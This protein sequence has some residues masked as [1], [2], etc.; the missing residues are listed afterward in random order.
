MDDASMTQTGVIAGTPQYMSPEQARGESVD[1]RS[2]LFSLGSVLYT[3]CTGRPP[4]RSEAAYGILRRITDSD[5]RPIREI[6]SD[7]PEWLCII[8]E[9][10]L[11]KHPADRFESASEVVDLFDGCLAHLQQP[12]QVELPQS[13][14]GKPTVHDTS[15]PLAS[16]IE[17][18]EAQRQLAPLTQH[19]QPALQPQ[20]SF[21]NRGLI[22]IGSILAATILGLL[23]MQMTNPTDIS[24]HWTG[25][26]WQHVS[27]ASVNEASDWYSGTFVD[28]SG[29][30]GAVRLEWSRLQR[31]YTGRWKVGEAESGEI[32][33]RSGDNGTLRGAVSVDPESQLEP[34]VPRLMEF[35][36]R[37]A[38]QKAQQD[39]ESNAG[40]S[41]STL[42]G[43]ARQSARSVSIRSPTQ[44]I[45]V[46]MAD[47][48]ELNAGVKR[49]D[50]IAELDT[51]A[52]D[53]VVSLK[54]RLSSLELD[55]EA[56]K[57]KIVA[58][59]RGLY[60]SRQISD[61]IMSQIKNLETV[62][63]RAA[64]AFKA[65][66]GS[67][68]EELQAQSNADNALVTLK[69]AQAD[70]VK[71]E[72]ELELAVVQYSALRQ[73]RDEIATEMAQASR[74][75]ILAP[76]AGRITYLAAFSGSD[77]VKEGDL[78][79]EVTPDSA[80]PTETSESTKPTVDIPATLPD[81]TPAAT[82]S[83][84][85]TMPVAEPQP[86]NSLQIL[87]AFGTAS[88]LA[89]RL[90]ESRQKHERLDAAIE[91]GNAK[92]TAVEK[93]LLALQE[94]QSQVKEDND[95]IR[96]ELKNRVDSIDAQ[97]P[98]IEEEIK[99]LNADRK[100]ARAEQAEAESERN[101]ILELLNTQLSAAQSQL[102]LNQ[103][104]RDLTKL[105]HEHGQATLVELNRAE[106]AFAGAESEY[107]QLELLWQ[108]YLKL[109][110]E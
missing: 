106:Q 80:E 51:S 47:G 45:I 8:I 14:R 85:T 15:S 98:F 70:V 60:A 56:A 73:Q 100:I 7:I 77:S 78:I 103:K 13:L 1:H 101:T 49:G 46:R 18:Q 40:R 93:E 24:G 48:I 92:L 11:A 16:T 109:G 6:N 21:S 64:E 36:W 9:R 20:R 74:L 26:N 110:R 62:K 66:N 105:G 44:G 5:P 30:R 57:S 104:T 97:K 95:L 86:S 68:A 50:L 99:A 58:A 32:T 84:A 55:E 89:K 69:K 33:L 61:A 2:D 79:C 67:Q 17:R 35:A 31:R 75:Q 88:E 29:R 63:Q 76:V 43:S 108:F 71:L 54:R 81:K 87:S 38:S 94:K 91:A 59:E 52:S 10:L 28:S 3:A 90:R 96:T 4:F 22:M 42:Q 53:A 37:P 27:L 34:G 82:A 83:T 12:L 107:Q 41:Q 39:F 102:D 19:T 65:G 23:T 25:D 72:A